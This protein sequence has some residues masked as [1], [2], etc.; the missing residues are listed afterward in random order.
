LPSG[1]HTSLGRFQ[2]AEAPSALRRLHFHDG[3]TPLKEVDFEPKVAVLDQEDLHAQGIMCS[4]FIPNGGD[5]DALGSCTCN[6]LTEQFSNI[7]SE[8]DF[9]AYVAKLGAQAAPADVY[10]DT[11]AAER[12]A[13][14]AYH[15]VTGQTGQSSQEWPPTDCGSSGPYLYQWALANGYIASELI[16]HGADNIISLF[17]GGAL[18]VG[19]PWAQAWF[20]PNSAGFIDGDGSVA[21]LQ[22]DL[23]QI[24]GGHEY[25]AAA[26][27]K[28]AFYPT[29]LVDPF[30]TVIRC[31]NH[32]TASWADQ[33]DF[34]MH[35]SL[36]VVLG[37]QADVRRFI[38]KTS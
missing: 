20:T 23:K 14:G 32:W 17:Q 16:A 35:L 2:A 30:N 4:S 13:I 22:Q 28:L 37:G 8:Q 29:G 6:T 19:S 33:G 12:A 24:A 9:S 1:T 31:R 25:T 36:L 15:A 5:P 34:Y 27:E 38:P 21:T 26:I 11:V 7:L 10:T 18:L 3:T